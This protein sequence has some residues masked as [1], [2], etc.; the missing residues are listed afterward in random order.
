ML[1]ASRKLTF[2]SPIPGRY[3]L[4]LS[5]NLLSR[6]Y[7]T[8]EAISVGLRKMAASL[9]DGGVLI[10]GN[11]QSIAAFRKIEGSLTICFRQGNW[12]S[13]GIANIALTQ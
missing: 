3:E 4:I 5:F 13:L 7:F 10:L 9:T 12:E 8:S 11:W 2:S 1:L 6:S